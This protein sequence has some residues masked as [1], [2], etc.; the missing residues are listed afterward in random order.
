MTADEDSRGSRVFDHGFGHAVLEILLVWSVLD[1][2]DFERVEVRQRL[3]SAAD[4]NALDHL[5]QPIL[6][7]ILTSK[8]STRLLSNVIQKKRGYGYPTAMHSTKQAH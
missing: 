4:P 2:G 7:V 5:Q 1:D 3:S 8:T 6:F